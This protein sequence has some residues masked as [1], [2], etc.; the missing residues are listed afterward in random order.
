MKSIGVIG[1]SLDI[2]MLVALADNDSRTLMKKGRWMNKSVH[3]VR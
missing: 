1:A 2:M 3:Q